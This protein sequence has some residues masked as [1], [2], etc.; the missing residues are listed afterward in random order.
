MKSLYYREINMLNKKQK[1]FITFREQM[2]DIIHTRAKISKHRWKKLLKTF[3]VMFTTHNLHVIIARY[4]D[5]F[6]VSHN[7]YNLYTFI[8]YPPRCKSTRVMAIQDSWW[9]D[10]SCFFRWLKV[11]EGWLFCF[12]II[13]WSSMFQ[14]TKNLPNPV[15]SWKCK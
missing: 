8:E 5:I 14:H 6:W 10:I 7:M 4:N 3:F 15:C 12:C 13:R 11:Q 1:I 9:R 2:A